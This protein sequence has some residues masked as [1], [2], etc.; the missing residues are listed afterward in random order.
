MARLRL[1]R[2]LGS[3]ASLCGGSV[4]RTRRC[5]GG[6]SRWPRPS[7]LTR[8]RPRLPRRRR[9]VAQQPLSLTGRFTVSGLPVVGGAVSVQKRVPGGTWKAVWSTGH[10]RDR[11]S[12]VRHDRRAHSRVADAARRRLG[13]E[14][15]ADQDRQGTR[16]H[17]DCEGWL[18]THGAPTVTSLC[19]ARRHGGRGR[20]R[21]Q[22]RCCRLA[23]GGCRGRPAAEDVTSPGGCPTGTPPTRRSRWWTTP[24]CS[25][26]PRRSSSTPTPREDIAL[27]ADPDEW[28]QMR[29]SLTVGRSGEHS[30]CRD[31]PDGRPVRLDHQEPQIVGQRTRGRSSK[32][33]DRYNLDGIDLDYESINFGSS[34]AK[35]TVRKYYPVAAALTSMRASTAW[36]PSRR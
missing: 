36:V 15:V 13:L 7:R 32:V 18:T 34:S 9:S 21:C 33:V 29:R 16:D 22:H 3:R 11:Q 19:A 5:G 1:A 25:R 24:T 17:D 30:D 27:T 26:T 4:T 10:Q 8:R 28:R 6:P 2:R 20:C 14:P 23:E 31:R 12:A 35:S